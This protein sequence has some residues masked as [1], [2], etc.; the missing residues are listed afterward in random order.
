MD[1]K[2][3]LA[4][5]WTVFLAEL[6][7]KT[8]LA[9]FT[10]GAAGKSRVSVFLGASAAL[11]LSTL[12]AVVLAEAVASRVNPRWT[13]GLAGALLVVMGGVYLYGALRPGAG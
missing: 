12:I 5:F 8:Q 13:Q 11:V 2:V 6:G 10:L 4:T 7:D 3:L 9:V 1:L